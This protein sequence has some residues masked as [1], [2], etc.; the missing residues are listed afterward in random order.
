MTDAVTATI[1]EWGGWIGGAAIALLGIWNRFGIRQ[2]SIKTDGLLQ[3][4]SRADRAE[5]TVE[6]KN[7][8]RDR[9][10][11]K[12]VAAEIKSRK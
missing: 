2:L 7:D 9:A 4:R 1:K 8:A 11:A 3:Y 10:D 5:A 6:E 12:D